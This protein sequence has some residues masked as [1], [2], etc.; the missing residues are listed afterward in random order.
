MA[1]ASGLL[2]AEC[3][4]CVL[5]LSDGAAGTVGPFG[6]ML[7]HRGISSFGG[8]FCLWESCLPANASRQVQAAFHYVLP[9]IQTGV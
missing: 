7:R 8:S 6:G 5:A 2:A 3:A 1:F 9:S 4:P